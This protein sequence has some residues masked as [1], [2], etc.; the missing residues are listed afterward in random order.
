[1]SLFIKMYR[2]G[3]KK[4][5]PNYGRVVDSDNRVTGERLKE[6]GKSIEL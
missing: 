3:A 5:T 6:I 2:I 4:S 1:M